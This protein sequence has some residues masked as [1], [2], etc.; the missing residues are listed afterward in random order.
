MKTKFVLVFSIS[1]LLLSACSTPFAGNKDAAPKVIPTNLLTG[2]PGTNGPVL[3]VKIDDTPP[4]HPQIGLE[5]ADVVYIEQVEGGLTRLA[6]IF[7]QYPSSIPAKIGPVRSARISDLEILSQYG[8]VGFAFSG[9]QHKL[10]PKIAAANLVDLSANRYPPSIYSRDSTRYAPTNLI[11]NPVPLLLKTLNTSGLSIDK[12]KSVGWNFGNMSNDSK[13]VKANSISEAD[14]TWPASSYQVRWSTNTKKWLI[15]YHH[16]PDLVASGSQL[17]VATFIVQ[18]VSITDSEYKDKLGGVTPFSNTVGSGLGYLLRDGQ[19][20][21][22]TWSRANES[23][24][25]NFRL[26]DGSEAKFAPSQI[27]IALTDKAPTFK[28]PPTPTATK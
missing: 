27:W 8:K 9:A 4:A 12:V 10:F 2:L 6:T 26:H 28:Y 13:F 18:I 11:L 22:I 16:Q 25:T 21:P 5:G 7:S 20:I 1:I 17:S 23:V 19:A 3:A 14:L 15:D 24:G